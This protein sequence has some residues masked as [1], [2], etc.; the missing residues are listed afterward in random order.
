[1][2]P[3]G[4]GVSTSATTGAS[5]AHRSSETSQIVGT[6]SGRGG[7]DRGRGHVLL[8]SA[9]CA[10]LVA[11][12]L[13][14]C[15]TTTRTSTC[16]THPPTPAPPRRPRRQLRRDLLSPALALQRVHRSALPPRRAHPTLTAPGD[17]ARQAPNR[18]HPYQRR[19]RLRL[20]WRQRQVSGVTTPQRLQ[21]TPF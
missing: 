8:L 19:Q 20:F 12:S 7:T 11:A 10:C 5:N 14:D 15:P 1:G 2:R 9:P 4:F 16:P 18:A 21:H 13:S 6:S 3:V 17:V